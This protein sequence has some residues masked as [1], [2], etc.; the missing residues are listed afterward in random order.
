MSGPGADDGDDRAR[1]LLTSSAASAGQSLNGSRMESKGL[2]GSPGKKWARRALLSSNGVEAPGSSGKG[3]GA[4]YSELL[5]LPY[6]LRGRG[7]LESGPVGPFGLL[8][9]FE[10]GCPC[11]SC[12]GKEPRR[13]CLPWR[14]GG[15]N[16]KLF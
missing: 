5:R 11:S 10:V 13:I 12:R 7:S 3:G 2:A 4:A 16:C 9:G 15:R 8:N 6:H 1:A 14:S